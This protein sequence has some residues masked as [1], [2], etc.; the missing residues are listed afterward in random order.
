MDSQDS[1]SQ[2]RTWQSSQEDEDW[3]SSESLSEDQFVSSVKN[4]SVPPLIFTYTTTRN[5][6]NKQITMLNSFA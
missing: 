5:N 6:A 3:P 2:I 4:P 1:N